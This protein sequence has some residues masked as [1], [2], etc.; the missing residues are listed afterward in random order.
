MSD[1]VKLH[2]VPIVNIFETSAEPIR[3][4]I[5]RER[6]LGTAGRT[7]PWPRRGLCNF[8]C[9]SPP[10]WKRRTAGSRRST[11]SLTQTSRPTRTARSTRRTSNRASWPTVSTSFSRSAPRWMRGALPKPMSSPL[12]CLPRMASW[13]TRCAPGRF[14]SQRRPHPSQPSRTSLQSHQASLPSAA[15]S[16]G[17]WSH[18]PPWAC[19]PSRIETSCGRRSTSTTCTLSS[20]GKLL[21]PTSFA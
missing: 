13:Q 3:L 8:S 5:A 14:V 1:A 20:I 10:E 11:T 19:A 2:C 17:A 18:T 7:T 16:N 4:N 6:F 21:G 12:I 15:S 9:K